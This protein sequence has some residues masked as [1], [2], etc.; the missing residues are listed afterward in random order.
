MYIVR[1]THLK[2]LLSELLYFKLV[3]HEAKYGSQ[4]SCVLYSLYCL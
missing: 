3:N 4:Q 1:L 2:H